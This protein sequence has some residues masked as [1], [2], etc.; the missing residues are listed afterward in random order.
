MRTLALLAALAC[1]AA[2]AEEGPEALRHS[3]EAAYADLRGALGTGE[4]ARLP[5]VMSAW[6]RATLH[7][8]YASG[9][10]AF[11]A[12]AMAAFAR[13]APDLAR[14]R[15][16]RV[17]RNGPTATGRW[18]CDN[19]DAP[20]ALDVV[21]IRFVEEGGRWKYDGLA[22][23]SQPKGGA[24]VPVLPQ[25]DADG[26]VRKPPE[27]LK[28]PDRPGLLDV[29]AIGWKVTV[30]VNGVAQGPAEDT[31]RSGIL[32]GGL[33]YGK[34]RIRIETVRLPKEDGARWLEVVV[35]TAVQG[36]DEDEE[37]VTAYRWQPDEDPTGPV[38]E[39]FEV[40]PPEGR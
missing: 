32:L 18:Q 33:K 20:Q 39:A 22:L 15:F 29:T 3:L 35:R 38:E 19:P 12:A 24:E 8:N 16:V 34:N 13:Q 37:P 36:G 28:A 6:T 7:N 1:F 25:V 11:D 5:E 14:H 10:R 40:K 21:D 9:G 17:R 30:T 27:L 2:S 26:K 4:K 23:S 31:S